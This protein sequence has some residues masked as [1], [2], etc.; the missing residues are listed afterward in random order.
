MWSA[1]VRT[2]TRLAAPSCKPVSDLYEANSVR[3]VLVAKGLDTLHGR[4]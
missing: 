4:P 1:T 3:S 2:P